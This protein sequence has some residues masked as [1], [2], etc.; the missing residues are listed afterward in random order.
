M[1]GKSIS[2]QEYKRRWGF[3][4][5]VFILGLSLVEQS[6]R[7]KICNKVLSPPTPIRGYIPTHSMHRGLK[8]QIMPNPTY[9][10]FF[11][12]YIPMTDSFM[13]QAQYK[14]LNNHKI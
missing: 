4:M 3:T 11:Y 5:K 12:T 2:E 14:I 7:D 10:T 1:W 9:H 13:N 8:P 6:S